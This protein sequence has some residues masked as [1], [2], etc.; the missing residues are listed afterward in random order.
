MQYDIKQLNKLIDSI[1][2]SGNSRVAFD[3]HKKIKDFLDKNKKLKSEDNLK[4]RKL[5]RLKKKCQFL[6][7]NHFEN[8]QETYTLIE[9]SFSLVF[10]LPS[11]NFWN[12]LKNNLIYIGDIEE[13]DKVKDNLR[14]ALSHCSDKI[15][16]S[17]DYKY[18][19]IKKVSDWV[20]DFVVN[21]GPDKEIDKVKKAE[22]LNNSSNL[23]K[24][25]NQD[26][27]K[28]VA[29]LNFYEILGLSSASP[30]GME[31]TAVFSI[32]N[33]PYILSRRGLEDLSHLIS[34]IEKVKMPQ[35]SSLSMFTDDDDYKVKSSEE[36]NKKIKDLQ[37]L[38]LDYGL[39]S[40]EF[41]A[42]QE[43]INNLRKK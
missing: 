35:E 11:Y 17:S 6:A 40:L 1:S 33:K 2:L 43:E 4:Y 41:K 9:E 38:S 13:R 36:K 27:E 25:N 34:K 19:V 8:W 16:N 31:E 37:K 22:Y 24:I 12:K 28:V 32:D 26:K 21:F 20:K 14:K 42:L 3:L 10:T 15:V 5:E 39:N 7:L 23:K 30:L 18:D 29:L